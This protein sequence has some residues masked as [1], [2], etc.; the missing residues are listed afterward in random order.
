[1]NTQLLSTYSENGVLQR[2]GG[3][4]WMRIWSRE[5][6][7]ARSGDFGWGSTV[8]EGDSER[9]GSEE[10]IKERWSVY[11][12]L[13]L[14]LCRY[15]CLGLKRVNG[16]DSS[17]IRAD[18]FIKRVNRYS[19][20][21]QEYHFPYRLI[22]SVRVWFSSRP[23]PLTGLGLITRPLPF[24]QTNQNRAR[25]EQSHTLWTGQDDELLPPSAPKHRCE[26]RRSA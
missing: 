2:E 19:C 12:D 9:R 7:R 13:G 22:G 24:F 15:L 25:M 16:S 11:W 8:S 5:G 18:P 26:G 14:V 21:G 23:G 4:A 1:M 17:N 20:P 6:E 10:R 3:V